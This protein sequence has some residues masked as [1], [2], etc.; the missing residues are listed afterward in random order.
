[1]EDA[2][3]LHYPAAAGVLGGAR[4]SLWRQSGIVEIQQVLIEEDEKYAG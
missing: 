4:F 2:E 3:S 1:M